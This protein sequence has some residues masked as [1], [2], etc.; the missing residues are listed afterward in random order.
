M[1]PVTWGLNQRTILLWGSFLAANTL[2]QLAFKVGGKSL[3][4]L[5]FGPQFLARAIGLPSVWLAITGY[6]AVFVLWILILQDMALS[7]AF[8]L[9]ALVYAVI[10]VASLLLFGEFISLWRAFGIGLI[11]T[12]V[13]LVGKQA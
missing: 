11:I 6:I 1:K 12:G 8:V 2:T 9:N 7:R 3:E 5:D 10:P 4:G 13:A